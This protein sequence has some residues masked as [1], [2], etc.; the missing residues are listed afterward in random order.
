VDFVL[1]ATHTGALKPD[2]L[3]YSKAVDAFG[4]EP[5][6]ILFV[7]DQF[8]NIAGAVA[9][10]LQVQYFDLRDVDGNVAAI[11][12]RLRMRP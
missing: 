2:A 8:R 6:R 7:D 9:A 11:E 1:D 5:T 3:A 12:A 4:F 10:G